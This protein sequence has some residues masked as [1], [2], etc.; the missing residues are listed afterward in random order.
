[1]IRCN[2]SFPNDNSGQKER[3][4]WIIKYLASGLEKNL[5]MLTMTLAD[6]SDADL[7]ARP[8]PGANHAAWQL[9]HLANAELFVLK[10]AILPRHSRL[11]IRRE[12]LAEDRTATIDDPKYFPNKNQL[13]DA[14]QSARAATISWVR[15]L[16]PEDLEKQTPEKLRSWEPTVGALLGAVPA[17]VAMHVGQFQV[18]RRKLGKPV[19]F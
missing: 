7:L 3:K 8:C 11:R 15:T 5:G 9:G 19:L 18:I 1:M 13:L 16:K 10:R 4:P 14:L 17:H 12:V 6:F 2:C